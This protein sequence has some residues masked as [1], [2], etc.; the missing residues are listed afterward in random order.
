MRRNNT[1]KKNWAGKSGTDATLPGF[2]AITSA[3]GF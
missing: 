2:S 1:P 3:S